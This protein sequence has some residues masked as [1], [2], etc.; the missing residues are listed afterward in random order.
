MSVFSVKEFLQLQYLQANE[1]ELFKALVNWGMHKIPPGPLGGHTLCTNLRV[2]ILPLLKFIRFVTMGHQEF[3]QL[4]QGILGN[5]LTTEE[6]NEISASIQAGDPTMM[7]AEFVLAN[8]VERQRPYAVCRLPFALIEA[9]TGDLSNIC[10]SF[11]INRSAFLVGIQVTEKPIPIDDMW[12]NLIGPDETCYGSG[13]CRWKMSLLGEQFCRFNKKQ[14]LLQ[15]ATYNLKFN[16]SNSKYVNL[17]LPRYTLPDNERVFTSDWLT[18][19]VK[20]PETH[21]VK[22]KSLIFDQRNV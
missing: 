9:N 13:R 22:V 5:L 7:P 4:C 10:F 16:C 3:S 6:Q 17:K 14:P 20:S 2:R 18:I 21:V 1:E 8:T 19:T 15:K 11:T 12:Y